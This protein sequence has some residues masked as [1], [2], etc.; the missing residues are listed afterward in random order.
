MVSLLQTRPSLPCWI[1]DS[2]YLKPSTVPAVRPITPCS[3]GP[4]RL[5][6]ASIDVAGLALG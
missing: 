5:V 2:E 6:G 1:I 4:T 3:D